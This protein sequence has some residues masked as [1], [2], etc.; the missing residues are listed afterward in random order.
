MGC[1]VPFTALA[2]RFTTRRM[3][4]AWQEGCGCHSVTPRML[5]LQE[6]VTAS[7][8]QSWHPYRLSDCIVI[9]LGHPLEVEYE[10]CTLTRIRKTRDWREVAYDMRNKN[11]WR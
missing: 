7:V 1:A 6:S 9:W 5:S 2:T 8:Q 4:S 11:D 10:P 3:H